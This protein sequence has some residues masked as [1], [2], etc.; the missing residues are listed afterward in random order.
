M[1]ILVYGNLWGR[2]LW[3]CIVFVSLLF[4]TPCILSRCNCFLHQT[5]TV[6]LFICLYVRSSINL[7]LVA[8]FWWGLGNDVTHHFNTAFS[9][10]DQCNRGG[11]LIVCLCDLS[12]TSQ[13]WSGQNLR[14]SHRCVQPFSELYRL[15]QLILEV[16]TKWH[17]RLHCVRSLACLLLTSFYM[18]LH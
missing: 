18:H 15:A 7:T 6:V 9:N 11:N 5:W 4:P 12:Y 14:E 17:I 8:G 13:I 10:I 2:C 3:W 16:R 1:L